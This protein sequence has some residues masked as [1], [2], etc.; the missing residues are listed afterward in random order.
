MSSQTPLTPPVNV[1][2]IVRQTLYTR[3]TAIQLLQ[4]AENETQSAKILY[5]ARLIVRELRPHDPVSE[6]NACLWFV[7]QNIRYQHDPEGIEVVFGPSELLKMIDQYGRFSEDCEA[8]STLLYSLLRAIGHVVRF[9]LYNF[10]GSDKV[11]H[12]NVELRIDKVWYML[13]PILTPDLVN[14]MLKLVRWKET[15]SIAPWR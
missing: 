6:A 8:Q 11:D 14:Y 12:M 2:P 7:R 10:T 5:T 15:I 1:P 9:A 3:Q 4:L 13:D